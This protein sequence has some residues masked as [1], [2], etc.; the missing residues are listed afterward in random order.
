MKL[1]IEGGSTRSQSVLLSGDGNIVR[2]A[3]TAGINPITDPNYKVAVHEIISHYMNDDLQSIYH[4]GS[5]CINDTVNGGLKYEYSNNF[6]ISESQ[7]IVQDDVMGS[8][9][10]SCQ[11]EPGIIVICGTGSIC[12]YYDGRQLLDKVASGGYLL[13]DEGSGFDLGRRLMR[14]YIRQRLSSSE[15]SIIHKAINLTPPE[16]ISH[17]YTISNVRRYMAQQCALLQHM[18]E[19][20]RQE[21]LSVS[22]DN[23][24]HNMIKPLYQKHQ[25]PVHFVGSVGYHF[26]GYLKELLNKNNILVGSF[27]ASAIEGL[28]NYHLN[29]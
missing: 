20:T 8:A 9:L 12:S 26:Q 24:Y 3:Q 11:G 14:L 1:I 25:K 28:L 19:G 29:G 15:H 2:R 6:G 4:Y 7:I 18:S 5:G 10:S 27:Q 17:L 16:L 13:G 21:V 23:M 22:F